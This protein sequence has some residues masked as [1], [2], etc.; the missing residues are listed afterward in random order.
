MDPPRRP[1]EIPAHGVLRRRNAGT[2]VRAQPGPLLGA[3]CRDSTGWIAAPTRHANIMRLE[4]SVRHYP[5]IR[6][7]RLQ[8]TPFAP[9][10]VG[11][12]LCPQFQRPCAVTAS[13]RL[14]FHAQEIGVMPTSGPFVKHKRN[15]VYDVP[16][17][18]SM[19]PIHQFETK[20]IPEVSQNVFSTASRLLS[21]FFSTGHI[22]VPAGSGWL[23]IR[24]LGVRSR[25][26]LV[27]GGSR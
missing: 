15:N 10:S 20:C 11:T 26:R 13:L 1:D 3:R 14:S 27:E 6:R 9:G 12:R 22:S 18:F 21:L 24:F 16:D 17:G 25:G 8:L 5:N 4:R 7:H 19:W 23:Q 2:W